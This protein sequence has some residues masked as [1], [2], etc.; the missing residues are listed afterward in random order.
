MNGGALGNM[1]KSASASSQTQGGERSE[2]RRERWDIEQAIALLLPGERVCQCGKRAVPG[3]QPALK[4][5]PD[6]G[7]FYGNVRACGSVWLCPYC[8]AKVGRGRVA[9]LRRAVDAARDAGL[10]VTLATFTVG[11][12]RTDHLRG[13]VDELT[14][15]M[16]WW[17]S[18]RSWLELAGRF[19]YVGSVR[20]LEVT[21]GEGT[22]WHP[23]AHALLFT[24]RPLSEH[25]QSELA[26]R[27]V[28]AVERMGGY[29]AQAV[30]L[31]FSDADNDV[32]GYL[33][34]AE[35]ELYGEVGAD[36]ERRGW[37]AAEEL[38]YWHTKRSRKNE[39]LT[40]WGLVRGLVATGWAEYADRFVEYAAAFHGRRQLYWS[41]GLRDRLGLGVEATDSELAEAEGEAEVL[42]VFTDD[43]WRAVV[44]NDA[45]WVALGVFEAEGLDA[46][47]AYVLG[48]V[49][50][51]TPKWNPW[52]WWGGDDEAASR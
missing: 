13:L 1:T 44:R 33:S 24:E 8:A 26:A 10:V 47:R 31:K 15:A 39:R 11:H 40:P 29:A 30:G 9:E 6:G 3:K 16:R 50:G 37:G 14:G 42:Y 52:G 36:D 51:F 32:A 18:G 25:D 49:E 12:K 17:R 5:A 21:W 41:K 48:L 23:H 38:A 20:N 7:A 35:R 28:V 46:F 43:E 34:K 45:R 4:V 27:W 22:G 19:G 2:R